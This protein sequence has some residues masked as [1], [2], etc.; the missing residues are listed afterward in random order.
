M[1]LIS[2]IA[3]F[4]ILTTACTRKSPFNGYS[5]TYSGIHYKLHKI[6]ETDRKVKVDDYITADFTYATLGDSIFFEGR[7]KVKIAKPEHKAGIEACF[8]MLREDESATFILSADDFFERTLETTLPS[9]LK[10]GDF[11]KIRIDLIDLQTNEQFE[12]EKMAFLKWIE[13]FGD[14]EKEILRQY[15]KNEKLPVQPGD[16]GYYKVMVENGN[17]KCIELGDTIV[18]N[19]SGKFLNGKYFDSTKERNQPL[20]FVYGTEWQV[21]D[22]IEKGLASMCEGEKAWLIFPSELAFGTKGSSTGI[23]PPFTSLIFEVEVLKV[24]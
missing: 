14:Y 20:Q 24:N 19:Y 5:L 2:F 12:D 17:G 16:S 11:I 9:F 23:I 4:L 1:R 6:G 7:R 3:I 15:L 21:I 8:L 13:D 18:I 10:A 22:G